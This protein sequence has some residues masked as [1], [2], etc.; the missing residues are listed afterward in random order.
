MKRPCSDVPI[1]IPAYKPGERL[2]ELVD[3]LLT[4]GVDAI[5]LVDDGSGPDYAE[6]FQRVAVLTHV[7]LVQHAVNLGKGSA[8]KTGMNYALVHFPDC[9]G[10]VTADADGQHHAG[11]IVRV[12]G[13]L[14]TNSDALIMG[15]REFRAGVPWKS[16][17][18][19]QI[20]RALTR[21]MVG[22]KLADSQTGLRGIPATLIA[23][24]LRVPSVGYEFELYMLI[25]C[26][27]RGL[28]VLQEPIRTIYLNGNKSSHFHPIFDS[29]RIYFRE[30]LPGQGDMCATNTKGRMAPN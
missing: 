27:H 26:K 20:T 1:V 13:R 2:L 14:R 17:L 8:L 30:G 4:L 28:P 5:I 24:L 22:Q 23:H 19:N 12:A 9:C 16:R 10:V 15:V 29:M 11:D 21:V 25:A 7:Y 18:G 3:A 6:Y